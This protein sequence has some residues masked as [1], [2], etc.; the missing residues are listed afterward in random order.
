[1]LCICL[2]VCLFACL[3][4]FVPIYLSVCLSDWLT[5]WVN[6]SV[7]ICL[8]LISLKC[9]IRLS[10]V[11]LR[12]LLLPYLPSMMLRHSLNVWSSMSKKPLVSTKLNFSWLKYSSRFTVPSAPA[13]CSNAVCLSLPS[14][15]RSS[16]PVTIQNRIVAKFLTANYCE[17]GF[18][19]INALRACVYIYIRGRLHCGLFI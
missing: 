3:F 17:R 5:D 10:A 2:S 7:Y 4:T 8:F 1:M 11:F 6:Y 18:L 14:K 13:P 9:H 16:V 19:S 12:Q 15:V